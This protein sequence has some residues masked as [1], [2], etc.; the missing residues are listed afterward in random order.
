MLRRE[1]PVRTGEL[2]PV[3]SSLFRVVDGVRMVAA[4]MLDLYERPLFHDS[5][6]TAADITAHAEAFG[7]YQSEH[8]VCAGPQAMI[9]E[10]LAALFD[11]KSV[12]SDWQ[13]PW[14][15]EIPAAID[16]ALLGRQLTAVTSTLGVRMGLAYARIHE[17]LSRTA[18]D[19]LAGRL[20][21]AI[22]LDFELLVPSRAHL[23]A[24]RDFS[25]RH[26]FHDMFDQAR[27]AMGGPASFADV[28]SPPSDLLGPRASVAL[29]NLFASI[30]EP[31]RAG[32]LREIA[33]YVVDY[34][35]FE[36]NA[37]RAVAAVQREINDLL[38]RP[39]PRS[40]LG[41]VHL[42][43]AHKLRQGTHAAARYLIDTLREVLGVEI[44]NRSDSTIAGH[45][46]VSIALE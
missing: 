1:N 8:G 22:A 23:P 5:L 19:G 17:A 36:R 44:V 26:C 14:T 11:G 30:C 25:E 46:G 28:M 33:G 21:E 6:V 42:A 43:S 13:C 12:E 2:D 9:D 16:Y 7:M 45:R 39:Q 40:P 37:L 18:L 32:L 31:S 24:Q 15:A 34:L 3:L 41:T 20:R 29:G 27:M 10:L 35:R 4:H 38:G